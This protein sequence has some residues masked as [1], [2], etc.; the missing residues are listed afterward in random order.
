V[1]DV[2]VASVLRR[3][4]RDRGE[5][6]LLISDTNRLSYA[7]AERR[8]SQL[9]RGLIALD[10]A[11]GAHVGLLAP[12]STEFVCWMLAAARIGAVVVPFTTFST[13]RE[14]REQLADSDVSILLSVK[15]FRS[16][17]YVTRLTELL[18]GAPPNEPLWLTSLPNLRRVVFDDDVICRAGEAI[19]EDYLAA[20]EDDVVGPDPL[21]IVYTSGSTSKPKGAIHTHQSL[22]THQHNL[23]DIRVLTADDR[24]FCNSPF[25]WIGGFGF[26]L[27]AVLV[28]GATLICSTATDANDTLALLEAERPTVTNGFAAGIAHLARHPSLGDRDLSSMR[29]GNLYP[30]MAADVRPAD[31]ELRHNMLGMTEAGGTYLLS[32]DEA[33]QPEAQRGSYGKPA[34]G[35]AVMVAEPEGEL[36]IRGPHVMQRYHRRSR[37]QCFDADGWFHTGDLVRVDSEGFIH[38]L[39]R[40]GAM[41]KT[42]GANVSPVEVANTITRVTGGCTAYVIGLP[43]PQRGQLVA[44]V[45]A[46]PDERPFDEAAVREALVRELSSYKVPRRIIAV[47]VARIPMLSSGKVDGHAL[48]E[49][50]DD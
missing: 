29:R 1:R 23:N 33:D 13:A 28:A 46:L 31:P 21:A 6:P 45:V 48:A 38:Y 30:I 42:A 10:V 41:I 27:L 39:G 14:L 18:D 7:A 25:F 4:A 34:P 36:C 43:D 2:T 40:S 15:G 32:S 37:E 26:G 50:F 12:N 35:F 9:A 11:K 49:L 22:L 5:H 3:R 8:S 47:P 17:N 44:A 19:S 16:H 20:V 24:L